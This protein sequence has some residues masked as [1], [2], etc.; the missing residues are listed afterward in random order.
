[1]ATPTLAR[2]SSPRYQIANR[3]I[4]TRLVVRGLTEGQANKPQDQVSHDES[5]RDVTGS[6]AA[7]DNR[8]CEG[9]HDVQKEEI[10]GCSPNTAD[11]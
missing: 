1:M 4:F 9:Q 11:M 3:G 10:H 8:P 5:D 6:E 2:T 7:V